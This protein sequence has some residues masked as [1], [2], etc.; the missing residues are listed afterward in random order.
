MHGPDGIVPIRGQ[1]IATRANTPNALKK[2]GFLGDDEYWFP[3]PLKN[4]SEHDLVILG[5]AREASK[6][7]GHESYVVDDSVV[8]EDIGKVLREFLPSAFPG[9][10]AKGADPEMEWVRVFLM[11]S[12]HKV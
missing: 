4:A 12:M 2:S 1:I 5:G 6:S 8:N 9:K 11:M 7:E 10:F 3:R